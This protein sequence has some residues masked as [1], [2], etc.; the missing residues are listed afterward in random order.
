MADI[1]VPTTEQEVRDKA[2]DVRDRL[3]SVKNML[4]PG[5]TYREAII[6]FIDANPGYAWQKPI[7]QEIYLRI[8]NS[9]SDPKPG[10]GL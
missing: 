6:A 1:F 2:K 10:L 9:P 5:S 4:A 8:T 3:N 7:L